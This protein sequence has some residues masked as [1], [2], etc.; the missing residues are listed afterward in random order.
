MYGQILTNKNGDTVKILSHHQ[1]IYIVSL[2]NSHK[3]ASDTNFTKQEIIDL[4]WIFP[5][6]KWVPEVGIK[7]FVPHVFYEN[8][9]IS[10]TW[11]NDKYDNSR[12]ARNIICRTKEE[13]IAL[14]DKMLG[15]VTN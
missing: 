1:D 15:A 7:Y 8:K 13:A 6:E 3:E 5:V 4:G 14:T 10:S 2:V 11:E 9:Y 12:L